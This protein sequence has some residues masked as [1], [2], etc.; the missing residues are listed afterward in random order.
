MRSRERSTAREKVM[1]AGLIVGMIGV[2]VIDG[3]IR[4]GTLLLVLGGV[5]A[6]APNV[7][8]PIVHIHIAVEKR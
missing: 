6:L 2:A 1:C 3:D 8:L 4:L 7:K 5:I